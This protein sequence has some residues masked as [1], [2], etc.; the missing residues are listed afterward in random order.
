MVEHLRVYRCEPGPRDVRLGVV[1]G[2]DDRGL[3]KYL[4]APRAE[5][6]E[7]KATLDRTGDL[8]DYWTR[9]PTRL[10]P[11]GAGVGMRSQEFPPQSSPP[12]PSTPA[13]NIGGS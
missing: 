7:L 12:L 10:L 8:I 3:T 6:L 13:T 2:R 11:N 5:V 9:Q 4:L 1:F